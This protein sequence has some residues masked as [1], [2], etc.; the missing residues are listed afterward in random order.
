MPQWRR[1]GLRAV[2]G[3]GLKGGLADAFGLHPAGAIL[4]GDD[5]FAAQAHSDWL[6]VAGL[7]LSDVG[8]L[9]AVG[10]AEVLSRARP[11]GAILK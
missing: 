9:G 10:G 7:R 5:R 3:V 8:P 1:V 4:E 11:P 2:W 6:P